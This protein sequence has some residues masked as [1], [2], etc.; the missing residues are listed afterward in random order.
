MAFTYVAG[1][2][3]DRDRVRLEIGDTI[4]GRALFEDSEIDDF[5]A[6][7][8]GS[9]LKAAA[10]ACEA[11]SVRFARDYTFAADG[12][13]FEKGGAAGLS[14]QYATI[15]RALRRRAGGSTTVK[16]TRQDAYSD[17]ISAE[18]ATV[19]EKVDFDRGRFDA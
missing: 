18:E 7:E 15:G 9:V 5:L 4:Q 14:V 6:Q 17:D 11:L 2:T 8:G 12:S 10:H 3:G 19:G 1:G 13:R 16:V